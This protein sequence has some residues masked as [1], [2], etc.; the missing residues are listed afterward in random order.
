MKKNFILGVLM[1]AVIVAGSN[2]VGHVSA[3][4]EVLEENQ[5]SIPAIPSGSPND[6]PSDFNGDGRTD[7]GVVRTT[8]GAGGRQLRWFIRFNGLTGAGS[9]RQLDWGIS[10]TDTLTPGDFDGDGSDDVAVWRPQTNSSGFY[11][12]QSRTNT[13]RFIRFGLP[14]DD[15]TIVRDYNNDGI[16]DAAIYR[17]GA[18]DTAQSEFW[19]LAPGDIQYR[20]NWG[21]G[22]DAPVPGDFTGDNR[23]DFAVT[24]EIGNLLYFFIHPGTGA[25][26]AAGADTFTPFGRVGDVV[27]PGDYD[28]DN[29]T[30]LA[31]TRVISGNINWFYR[32]SSIP[33][34]T[35]VQRAWGRVSLNDEEVQGDYDGDGRTDFAVFRRSGATP[36]FF[37]LSSMTGSGIVQQWG[38]SGDQTVAFDQ[39]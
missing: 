7:Y 31:V 12:F 20:V 9:E 10:T 8:A 26:D 18:T 19:W 28:N 36:S 15:S 16:D 3:Q 29:R 22:S 17:R 6:A 33:G 32:P 13:F 23:A 38:L 30:D 4:T 2:F 39:H 1:I 27:V 24:R 34:D 37:A 11:V 14:G 35:Y 21:V 25:G 5:A